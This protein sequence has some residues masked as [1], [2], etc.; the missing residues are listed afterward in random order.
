VKRF[1]NAIKNAE[2]GENELRI[3]GEIT[4]DQDFWGWLFGEE[5]TK[6]ATALQKAINAFNGQPLTVW[7]NSIGGEVYAASVIYTALRDYPGNVTVK[8]D[9]T[10]ISAASVI[11]MAGDKILMSPT[12]VM[13]IHNPMTIAQ[14]EEKDMKKAAAILAEVKETIM[15]AYTSKTGKSR[16]EISDLM[17][18]ETWMSA[19]KAIEMGFADGMLFE[20]N[21][22][23]DVI[24]GYVRGA[25]LVYNRLD[26]QNTGLEQFK[27]EMAK[28]KAI[29]LINIESMR[30]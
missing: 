15:N 16:K 14:G 11:A 17:D 30:F 20:E 3:D 6:S 18:A 13:M 26:K 1:W 2:T 10:A 7:I 29:A 21:Q 22:A 5:D 24:N 25:Q 28:Q 19:N 23:E 27:A 12:A 9:G 8:I 4:M